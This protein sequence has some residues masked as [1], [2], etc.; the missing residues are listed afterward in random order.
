MLLHTMDGWGDWCWSLI[1]TIRI[2]DE[3]LVTFLSNGLVLT[4]ESAVKS[5]CH[6]SGCH[7]FVSQH[8]YVTPAC[9][10]QYMGILFPEYREKKKKQL[11]QREPLP[12]LKYLKVIPLSTHLSQCLRRRWVYEGHQKPNPF[13]PI[14]KSFS[15][16][17]L[18][19]RVFGLLSSSLLLF[20]Q[21]FGRYALRTHSVIGV[22]SLSF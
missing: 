20:P 9:F 5:N 7:S 10:F 21:C 22:G 8:I 15:F 6:W 12:G 1:I 2:I 11:S 4:V 3:D 19:L 18:S 14:E 13:I 16:Y 17:F